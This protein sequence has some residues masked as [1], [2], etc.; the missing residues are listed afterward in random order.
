M[1]MSTA[2]LMFL[3]ADTLIHLASLKSR[4]VP[5]S[6]SATWFALEVPKMKATGR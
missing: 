5:F 3:L 6:H 1:L 2:M 4:N